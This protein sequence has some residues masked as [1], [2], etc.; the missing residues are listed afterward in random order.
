M[1]GQ[2]RGA[3]RQ[4]R[5]PGLRLAAPAA[6]LAGA[7]ALACAFTG[8]PPGGPPRT[9][10]PRVVQV[11]PESG[12]V[13][14]ATPHQ[15][16]IDFDE[17]IGEQIA[18]TQRDIQGA[19]LLSPADKWSVN[20][21]RTHLTVEPKGG[22]KPDRVYRVE[23]LPVIVDL[24]QNRLRQGKVV[25][26]ST[27]PQIPGA[28]LR[29]AVVDWTG[30]HLAAAAL[31]EAVLLPDSLTY[32]T[33]ADSGGNFAL[34]AMPAGDYVVYGVVDLNGD[35]HRQPREPFDTVRVSLQDSAEVGLYAFQHD[36]VGPRLRSV[37]MVDSLTLRLIFDRPIDPTQ[38]PD[39]SMVQVTPAE[40]TTQL[41][42][43][44]S[45][46][47]P[48]AFDSL[49][50]AAAAAAAA[51]DSLRRAQDTTHRAP[52]QR[53]APSR[54]AAPAEPQRGQRQGAR[55]PGPA[56]GPRADT[57]RATHLLA[58]RPAPT[59]RRIVRLVAPLERGSRYFVFVAG[60][61]GLTGVAG[62]ESRS[63]LTVPKKT[64]THADSLRAAAAADSLRRSRGTDTTQAAP[65]DTTRA[66]ADTARPAPADTSH[67]APPDTMR[68]PPDT[69]RR[70]APPLPAR[71][72]SGPA[73][74]PPPLPAPA[75]PW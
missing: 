69:T 65:P 70:P 67:A 75:P 39:T 62:H 74:P 61:R 73:V 17:V 20:W 15:V 9:I 66:P 5:G 21:H 50:K 54:P 35:H 30:G 41:L 68:A 12:A 51:R 60:M 53:G 28:T 52:A 23:L 44:Q 18:A 4:A 22:F 64:M 1:D 34:G 63:S 11:V 3:R 45:V 49:T 25:V 59:D 10:P 32:R 37:E 27:G 42:A 55:R 36:T 2:A 56:A 7:L 31:V 40:D 24:H 58:L 46:L 57:T 8:P 14:A 43:L 29:G 13:L 19:V 38:T 26:F 47:T 16:E 6:A 72:D 71:R 33:L 48:A